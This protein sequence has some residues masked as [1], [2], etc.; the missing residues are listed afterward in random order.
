MSLTTRTLTPPGESESESTL[1]QEDVFSTLSN[2]RRRYVLR[3]LLQNG[4]PVGLRDLSAR[5][6][7]WE[8]G[9]SLSEVTYKQ[10]VRVYTALRQSHLPKL[11]ETGIVR[12]DDERGVVE[13]T[14]EMSELEVYLDIVPHDEISWSRYYLGLGGLNAALLLGAYLGLFPLSL[15]SGF[16]WAVFVVVLFLASALAHVRYESRT[17]LGAAGRPPA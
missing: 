16:A 7:A 4:E 15:L 17:R 13:P 10:R 5:L 11:A 14:P 2:R 3:H 8:N 6:A 9:V 12:Y 1:S